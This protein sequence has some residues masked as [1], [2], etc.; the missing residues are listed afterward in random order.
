MCDMNMYDQKIKTTFVFF[1]CMLCYNK[2][3]VYLEIVFSSEKKLY[4]TETCATHLLY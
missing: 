1:K 4:E 3:A 2:K